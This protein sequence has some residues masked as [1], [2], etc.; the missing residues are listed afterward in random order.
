MRLK[1]RASAANS[2]DPRG[3]RT[4]PKRPA[5][6][7]RAASPIRR[8]GV[9]TLRYWK[10]PSTTAPRTTTSETPATSVIV[11]FHFEL[12]AC[13]RSLIVLR[14]LMAIAVIWPSD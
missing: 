6:I 3:S 4:S 13:S 11:I 10:I 7:F 9:M 8:S 2:A 14:M 1:S 5:A 12:A